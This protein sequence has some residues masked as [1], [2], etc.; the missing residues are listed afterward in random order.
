MVEPAPSPPGPAPRREGAGWIAFALL[1]AACAQA[2][3]FAM[4]WDCYD[5]YQFWVV[6][7]AAHAEGTGNV[8]SKEERLRLGQEWARRAV[9]EQGPKSADPSTRRGVAASRRQ[10]LETYSTPW[11]YTLFGWCAGGDY[12]TDL[13]RFQHAGLFAFAL[14]V[15]GLARLAGMGWCGGALLAAFLVT[16]FAPTLSDMRVGNVNRLQLAALSLALVLG[17]RRGAWQLAAGFVLGLAVLF[18]PN[19]AYPALVLGVGWIALGRWDRLARQVPAALAGAAAA[20]GLSSAWFVGS[21]TR[22]WSDWSRVLGELMGEYDHALSKGN[23]ALVRLLEDAGLPAP[24]AIV[25]VLMLA[26]LAAALVLRRRARA[27]ATLD[28]D[29]ALAGLGGALSVSTSRLA[30]VHYYLLVV[31]LAAYLLRPAAPRWARAGGGV[32]LVLVAHEPLK[33]LLRLEDTGT[34]AATLVGVGVLALFAFT[35]LDLAR[36]DGA[37]SLPR[38][39]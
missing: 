35:L 37:R 26:G 3:I 21:G 7:Q 22:A 1:L 6:G 33:D 30:W 32:A 18:K 24:G 36:G 16:F 29:L 19:L 4:R 2:S 23:F 5:F 28:E 10:D 39:A 9:D 25:G 20:F 38:G 12:D 15:I 11:L 17:A 27:A 14:A 8:W 31:P 34:L 13:G